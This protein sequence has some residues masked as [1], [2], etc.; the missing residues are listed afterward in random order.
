MIGTRGRTL[1]GI[2]GTA[3]LL[4][5]GLLL[6]STT[7]AEPAAAAD[8]RTA[9]NPHREGDLVK[10]IP[11]SKKPWQKPRSVMSLG[12]AQLGKLTPGE[13]IEAASDIELTICIRPNPRHPGGGQPCVGKYHSFDPQVRVKLVLADSE[14]EARPAQTVDISRTYNYECTE[15]RGHRTRHCVQP[16]PW[17]QKT[18]DHSVASVCSSCHVNL[19]ASVFHRKARQGHKVV[20]GSSDDRKRINQGRT[21]L[22]AVAYPSVADTRPL[23]TWNTKRRVTSRPKVVPKGA[24]FKDQVVYSQKIKGTSVGDQL[25]V[26]TNPW[27][28]N[29]GLPYPTHAT[30]EVVISKK[31]RG[32]KHN[33]KV[34]ERVGPVSV[35]NGFTCTQN[36]SGHKSPCGVVKTGII[37]VKR[38][39]PFF[40]NLVIGQDAKGTAPQYNR[41]RPGHRTKI[42]KRGSMRV[43]KFKGAMS[44]SSCELKRGSTSYSPT[45]QPADPRI[46]RLVSDLSDF[47]LRSGSYD[48]V[49]RR[50]A[51]RLICD[52]RSKGSFGPG[53]DASYDCKQRALYLNP[54]WKINTC[55]EAIGAQLFQLLTLRGDVPRYAGSCS[56]I[57]DNRLR[58]QWIANHGTE[59]FCK[60]NAIYSL[61]DHKWRI[62]RCTPGKR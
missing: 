24:K 37:S 36:S 58:C 52:W 28:K 4:A 14:N 2:V 32:T 31:R 39:K 38:T 35:S 5:L 50:S 25:L 41:W 47:G 45:K 48:C 21:Q 23:K 44:C 1:H 62:D 43:R 15:K 22:S 11:I 19:V 49:S 20:V 6:C 3:L 13:V 16:I 51:P 60:G 17:S 9:V 34:A 55:K 10:T 7:L 8:V 57:S 59:R 46:R 54:R 27:V 33:G 26:D 42:L 40:I 29:N 30:Y 61:R 18:I 56:D 53:A 12:P